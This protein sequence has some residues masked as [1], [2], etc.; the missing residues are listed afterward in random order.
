MNTQSPIL[1]TQSPLKVG[2]TGQ[3]GLVGKHLYNNLGLKPE[4][5]HRVDF[6]KDFFEDETQ[7]DA[8]VADCD[9][10]VHLAAMNRHESEQFIYETNVALANQLVASL[11][12]TNSKA[13]VL[14][15]S[16]T[17]EE[18]DNLYGKSKREGREAIVNWANE[19]GGKVTGLI[20]P[21]VFGAFGKPFYNSF[22][23]TFCHQ[24]THGE[25]P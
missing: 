22:V 2:I 9:V 20:I 1:N 8:F 10:I 12:R 3:N 11:K 21:N 7:L 6:Q 17:Q 4:E 5:F 13:H 23:A 19:N 16:S 25:T 18:R 15:S 24:L 14:I